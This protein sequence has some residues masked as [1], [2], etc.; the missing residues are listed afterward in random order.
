MFTYESLDT[1]L[2][3]PGGFLVF[4]LWKKDHSVASLGLT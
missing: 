2:S 4:L 3:A 1:N